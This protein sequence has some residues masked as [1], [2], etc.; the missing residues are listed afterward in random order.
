MVSHEN[1]I[2]NRNATVDHAS[3]AVSWL[4]HFHD[5]GLIGYYLFPL[6]RG[7]SAVHFSPADFL[8]RPLLWLETISRFG[9]SATSAP[10]FAFEYCLRDDKF[11]DSAIPGLRPCTLQVMM[12]AFELVRPNTM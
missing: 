3:I 6:L 12:N 7:G 8:R 10:N 9:G 11:P 4:P 2:N 5:M 1:V